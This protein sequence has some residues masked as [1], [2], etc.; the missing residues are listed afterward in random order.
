MFLFDWYLLFTPFISVS[1]QGG[2]AI[3]TTM[4]AAVCS[5]DSIS[6]Y[7]PDPGDFRYARCNEAGSIGQ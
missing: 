1:G 7:S 4:R 6:N 2:G 3:V 5:L